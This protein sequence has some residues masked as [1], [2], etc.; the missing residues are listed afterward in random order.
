MKTAVRKPP[1]VPVHKGTQ[2]INQSLQSAPVVA[3]VA[4]YV[5]R[6]IYSNDPANQ[7]IEY[8]ALDIAMAVMPSGCTK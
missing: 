3:T 4:K 7:A 2:G 5:N 6:P 8:Q 1:Q